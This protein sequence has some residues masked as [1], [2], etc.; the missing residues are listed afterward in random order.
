MPEDLR[1]DIWGKRNLT[2]RKPTYI[3]SVL[4]N[5]LRVTNAFMIRRRS[6][7]RDAMGA[8]YESLQAYPQE[9]KAIDQWSRD[10]PDKE[11]GSSSIHLVEDDSLA[12]LIH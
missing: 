2:G 1:P 8:Y 3:S 10:H 11:L 9:H 4:A 12:S 7:G 5:A 6:E